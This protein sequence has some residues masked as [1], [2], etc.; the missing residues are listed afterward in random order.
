[1]AFSRLAAMALAAVCYCGPALAQGEVAPRQITTS[2]ELFDQAR[3]GNSLC[4]SPDV[5]RALCG[6]L[7]AYTFDG[8]VLLQRSE[9]M[10]GGSPS[11]IMTITSPVSVRDGFVC[12]PFTQQQLDGASFAIDGRALTAVQSAGIRDWVATHYAVPLGG[13]LCDARDELDGALQITV[14]VQAERRPDLGS[15]TAI[16]VRPDQAFRVGR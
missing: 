13:E 1:M 9:V 4:V 10:L 11:V 15:T 6:A 16:W 7:L 2:D 8:E 5:D 12:R 14:V 3:Q